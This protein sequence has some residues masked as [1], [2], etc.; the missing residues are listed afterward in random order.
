MRKSSVKSQ[1]VNFHWQAHGKIA[2]VNENEL[3]ALIRSTRETL[4][5]Q[6][7]E[8]DWLILTLGSSYAYRL[9]E[10]GRL[11]AN[12]HKVPQKEFTKELLQIDEMFDQL[13]LT[14]STL[15]AKNP[16]LKVI[17]TVSPVR[18]FRDGLVENNRS[19]ARL[20]EVVQKLSWHTEWIKYF[21]AYEIQ[22]DQLRDYRFYAKDRVHPSSEAVDFIWDRFIDSYFD[23][24]AKDF[25]K[26][27]GQLMGMMNHRPIHSGSEEHK[28]FVK[29]TITRLQS[30]P[31]H[32]DV[33]DEVSLLEKQL[34]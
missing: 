20:I 12:C 27:W 34:K 2:S 8:A 4:Q 22:I 13:S 6:V 32:V 15:K 11:V 17:L 28:A 9:K 18:H 31:N 16:N 29:K 21:P 3:K 7:A 30:L 23:D 33:S 5:A 1:G 24:A 19:K 10:S 25:V 14:L 26:E